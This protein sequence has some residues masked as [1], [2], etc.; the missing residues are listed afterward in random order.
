VGIVN[1]PGSPVWVSDNSDGL[2]ALY[3]G[4]GTKTNLTVTIPLLVGRVACAT[5]GGG[6]KQT[7]RDWSK[8]ASAA[9]SVASPFSTRMR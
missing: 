7:A 3:D 1:A 2:S 5:G 8:S 9:S 6:K 4:N